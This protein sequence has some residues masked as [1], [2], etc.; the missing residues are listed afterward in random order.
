MGDFNFC[1]RGAPNTGLSE[2]VTAVL[3]YRGHRLRKEF[4]HSARD[5]SSCLKAPRLS[6][7]VPVSDPVINHADKKKKK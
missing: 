7:P 1:V 5:D 2:H 3:A 4:D 6:A